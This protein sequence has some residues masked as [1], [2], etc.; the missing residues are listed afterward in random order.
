[1]T[2][3]PARATGQKSG[4]TV[5]PQK[6]EEARQLVDHLIDTNRVVLFMEGERVAAQCVHSAQ[7][8][9]LLEKHQTEFTSC[10][11][12]ADPVVAQVLTDKTKWVSFPQLFVDKRFVGGFEAMLGLEQLGQL[13]GSLSSKPEPPPD[14]QVH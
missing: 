11:V 2:H 8:V 5:D 1:M 14:E 6:V 9:R 10:D 12:L 4:T 3:A 7:A 13:A